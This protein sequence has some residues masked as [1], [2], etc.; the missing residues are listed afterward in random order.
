[1]DGVLEVLLPDGANGNSIPR[2]PCG[3]TWPRYRFHWLTKLGGFKPGEI[4]A[5]PRLDV[6]GR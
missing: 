3:L 1:M 6:P 5:K 4:V 2:V